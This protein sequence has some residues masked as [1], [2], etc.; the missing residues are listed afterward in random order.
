[1][2]ERPILRACMILWTPAGGSSK[3]SSVSSTAPVTQGRPV[4]PSLRSGSLRIP[5]PS[6]GSLVRTR[7]ELPRMN[8]TP[9]DPLG[10]T[11]I[12]APVDAGALQLSACN[13]IADL[14]YASLITSRWGHH[15]ENQ[16]KARVRRAFLIPAP[17]GN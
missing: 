3:R 9:K 12:V 7:A 6:I 17:D 13:K 1:P 2:P 10:V 15:Q 14:N 16:E 8:G 5:F 11:A 4:T